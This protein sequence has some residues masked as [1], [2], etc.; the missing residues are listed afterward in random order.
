MNK[1]LITLLLILISVNIYAQANPSYSPIIN[2]TQVD[3]FTNLGE[4][5]SDLFIDPEID[6]RLVASK[7]DSDYGVK[8]STD[9]GENWTPAVIN[10]SPHSSQY[11][12]CNALSFNTSNSNIGYLAAGIDLYKTIDRGASWDSTEFSDL[13]PEYDLRNFHD[14]NFVKL[15]PTR[16][17]IIFVSNSLIVTHEPNLFQSKDDGE[18]WT[19][20]DSSTRYEELV[21]DSSNPNVIY[22]I[23]QYSIIKKTTDTGKTWEDINNNLT[24]YYGNLSSLAINKLNSNILYC[25]QLFDAENETW[26]LSIT[27]NG[28]ESW[29]RIDSTLLEINPEG[30]VYTILMD[31]NIE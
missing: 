11:L 4:Y 30:S 21:F 26:R 13:F 2:P 1:L 25:G 8:I 28:G 20:S 17:E 9:N 19:I 24:F 6:G 18:D 23:E 14:I 22:G 15:H 27:T 31:N 10:V 7:W 3:S 12:N 5:V 16:Q 29:E